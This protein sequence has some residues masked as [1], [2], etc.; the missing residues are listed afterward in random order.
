MSFVIISFVFVLCSS[1]AYSLNIASLHPIHIAHLKRP[2]GSSNVTKFEAPRSTSNFFQTMLNIR[3]GEPFHLDINNWNILKHC[4]LY[5][6]LTANS[7][8]NE[9]G[10]V[11]LNIS[12]IENPTRRFSPELT[13][14]K[15]STQPEV[16]GGVQFN[17]FFIFFSL[18]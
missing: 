7:F 11:T 14:T 15:S 2:V 3:S 10:E 13:L 17:I 8:Q 16:S 4:G 9:K 12:G 5:T 6:N 1:Y 18:S